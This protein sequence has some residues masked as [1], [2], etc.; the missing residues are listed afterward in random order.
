MARKFKYNWTDEELIEWCKTELSRSKLKNKDGGKFRYIIKR[1]LEAH[2]P[3]LSGARWTFRDMSDE[4]QKKWL[5]E[6]EK[7]P[8]KRKYQKRSAGMAGIFNPSRMYINGGK[9]QGGVQCARCLEF[10][11]YTSK[12]IKLCKV[13][14]NRSLCLYNL[15]KDSNLWNVRDSFCNSEITYYEKVFKIGIK[16]DEK[17]QNYLTLIGYEFIF[18]ENYNED[19]Y[20]KKKRIDPFGDE[21][22]D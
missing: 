9:V 16:V 14:F 20:H 18:K 21:D 13:C 15:H 3:P 22:D 5:E 10:R 11:P 4:D 1:G 7:L 12:L 17:T 6:R 8:P 2:L 19:E